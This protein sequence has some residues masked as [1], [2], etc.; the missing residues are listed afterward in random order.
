M[1]EKH[2]SIVSIQSYCFVKKN[3][4]KFYLSYG[5]HAFTIT[6]FF[7]MKHQDFGIS[8][9]ISKCS[10]KCYEY[11]PKFL[12]RQVLENNVDPDQTAPEGSTLFA[13]LSASFGHIIL[14]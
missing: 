1:D 10:V 4:T 11:H 8:Q 5:D 9:K 12:N 3:T 2:C 6:V 7:S 13:I 14:W